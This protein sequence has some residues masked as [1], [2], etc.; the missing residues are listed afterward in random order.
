MKQ[1]LER[2]NIY[3]Q[4]INK[5]GKFVAKEF[6]EFMEPAFTEAG[7]RTPRPIG[8]KPEILVVR[9]DAAGDFVLFSGFLRELR[10]VYPA[11]H[12]TLVVS[13][14]SY[15][16]AQCCPYVDNLELNPLRFDT[17]SFQDAFRGSL[18]FAVQRLMPHRF[19]LA[20]CGRLGIRA[21]SVVL[22]Y[23]SGARQRVAYT[24]DRLDPT[25]GVFTQVGWDCMLTTAVPFPAGN[26]HD[27]DMNFRIL[28]ALLQLP[29]KNRALEIWY[30]H[31][32]EAF[33]REKLAAFQSKRRRIYAVVPGASVKRKQ[34]PVENYVRMLKP[35]L[36]KEKDLGLVVLGGP[37]EGPLGEKLRKA[38]GEKNVVNLAGAT[39]FRQ[40]GA[41]LACC[42]LYIGSD[43]SL[44]HMAAALGLPVL[45]IHCFAASLPKLPSSIPARFYPYDVPSVVLMPEKPKD[46]CKDALRYGC[47]RENEMHCIRGVTPD[48]AFKGYTI[49]RK[50]IEEKATEPLFLK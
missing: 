39:N 1:L 9:D 41:T 20:F 14:R 42:E 27:V 4:K 35:V 25:S 13:P 8:E 43:T 37:G 24:Q 50:Q 5:E 44:L 2:F 7:F 33:A 36:A 12:I 10:R 3:W 11:A 47:E 28:E 6:V 30:T 23:M 40:A 21:L 48:T 46:G 19:D 38:L 15:E 31:K 22:A 18:N 45:T 16:L 26:H 29:I 32:D 49:L 34:W 17:Q